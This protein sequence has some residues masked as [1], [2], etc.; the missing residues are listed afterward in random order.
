M[1]QIVSK[2][3]RELFEK[4]KKE[5][6]DMYRALVELMRPAQYSLQI[7]SAVSINAVIMDQ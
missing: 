3:N 7:S 5:D 4:M 1:L 2:A 6:E